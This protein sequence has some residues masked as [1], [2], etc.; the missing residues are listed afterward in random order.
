[1]MPPSKEPSRVLIVT[2]SKK[3]PY[4]SMPNPWMTYG[5]S[6]R[7]IASGASCDSID[8]PPDLRMP[9]TGALGGCGGG[10][11]GGAR[12]SGTG[13]SRLAG[14]GFCA[15]LHFMSRSTGQPLSAV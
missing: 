14:G 6:T 2:T 10:G 13:T 11:G 5:V 15:Q 4:R 1:M 12:L 7:L 3:S 8:Q 9:D